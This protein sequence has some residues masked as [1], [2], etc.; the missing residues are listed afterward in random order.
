MSAG[1][2]E[3]RGSGRRHQ[4]DDDR[5]AGDGQQ[6]PVHVRSGGPRAGRARRCAT[7]YT[8]TVPSDRKA[9]GSS[10]RPRHAL[11]ALPL[12]LIAVVTV[13]D[14]LAPDDVHV[15]PLL[16]AAPAFTAAIGGYRLVA[17]IGA[18]AVATQL[19]IGLVRHGWLDLNHEVQILSLALV[20]AFIVIFCYVRERREAQLQQVRSVSEAAQ[21]V[22][23]RPLPS[24]IG[25]LTVASV[26]LA[27]EA[28]AR[29]GGDLYAAARANGGTRLIIGDVRGKGLSSIS[30]AALLLGAFREAAHQHAE[31]AELTRYLEARVS[32][33]LA[34]LTEADHGADE[35]FITAA[36]LEIPDSEPVVHVIN[37]GHPPPLL[38]RD[39]TV[40]PLLA[41]R[42]ETP[43]G[44]GGL[45]RTDY[46]ADTFALEDHDLLLLY[47]DGVTE[48]RNPKGVFYPLAE[49]ITA[50]ARKTPEAF[51]SQLR[52][53]L[54]A[55]SG[56][57]L[58]DDAAMIALE[59]SS[60]P[61]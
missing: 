25:P 3:R 43:L 5:Q 18:L 27:A 40:T 33:D 45:A 46:A 37:C 59:R 29:I 22:V 51:L 35:D 6:V 21:R 9:P 44:L 10:W 2:D 14:I 20:T 15:G 32:G 55:Y 54:L 26:Y 50:W 53:D 23:L 47:T 56:G 7:R 17:S 61:A 41:S 52:D 16:V 4:G 39:G 12:G 48:A 30:D 42:P 13:G 8:G 11:V 60:T 36:V 49:R 19:V 28:E 58:G 38:V 57:S 31:L 1:A 34:E 24:R